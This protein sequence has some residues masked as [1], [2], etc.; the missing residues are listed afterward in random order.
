M[1]DLLNEL[2][3]LGLSTYQVDQTFLIIDRWLE[4]KYPIMSQV[5]R[6]Q[7]LREILAENKERQSPPPHITHLNR[8]QFTATNKHEV[9]S[10]E[11]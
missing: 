4:K 8:Q 10:L 5:Y 6:Q 3:D 11:H 1:T 2:Y 9:L 7:M